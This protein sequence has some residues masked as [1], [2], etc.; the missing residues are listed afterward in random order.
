[1]NKSLLQQSIELNE[2]ML[3]HI[4]KQS[5]E[6]AE[7]IIAIKNAAKGNSMDA[8]SSEKLPE[9]KTQEYPVTPKD[10]FKADAPK[11]NVEPTDF[12]DLV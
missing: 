10:A 11:T 7:R 6:F 8:G 1:M 9:S 3:N 12:N 5:I 2:E 4:N